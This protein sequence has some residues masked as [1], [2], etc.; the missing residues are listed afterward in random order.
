MTNLREI[1]RSLAVAAEELEKLTVARFYLIG[2]LERDLLHTI[3]LVN[4]YADKRVLEP[5]LVN[6][7]ITVQIVHTL[8][9]LKIDA[10][11]QVCNDDE[12]YRISKVVIDG[13]ETVFTASEKEAAE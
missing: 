5:N 12:F 11:T 4:R 3:G 7:G 13:K 10:G 8:N 9:F 6:Y 1:C 2:D